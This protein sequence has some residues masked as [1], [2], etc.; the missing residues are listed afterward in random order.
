M[1]TQIHPILT[2]P[3]FPGRLFFTI[4]KEKIQDISK[5]KVKILIEK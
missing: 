5:K 1:A 3:V 4:G 2:S